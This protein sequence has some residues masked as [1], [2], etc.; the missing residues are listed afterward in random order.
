MKSLLLLLITLLITNNVKAGLV[1]KDFVFYSNFETLTAALEI[2]NDRRSP[3]V[4]SVKVSE[5][6]DDRPLF[7]TQALVA[8]KARGVVYLPFWGLRASSPGEFKVC[9]R[10]ALYE[11]IW[12]CHKVVI[13][14]KG[15]E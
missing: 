11:L 7:E 6:E 8:P 3:V 14:V 5:M 1:G 2:E 9:S 12:N 13:I 10:E 15:V 4:L